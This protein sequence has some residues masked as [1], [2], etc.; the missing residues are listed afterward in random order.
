MKTFHQKSE[1]ENPKIS[2]GSINYST[3]ND[4]AKIIMKY[5]FI[6]ASK[7]KRSIS[8]YVFSLKLLLKMR[9]YI[10]GNAIVM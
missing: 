2:Q 7:T 9:F 4:M 3:D 6:I 5:I 8:R 10:S 1:M